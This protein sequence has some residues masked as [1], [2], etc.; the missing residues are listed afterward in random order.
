MSGRAHGSAGDRGRAGGWRAEWRLREGRWAKQGPRLPW[1]S[2]F[3]YHESDGKP[4]EDV[5]IVYPEMLKI[6]GKLH[7][8]CRGS[9]VVLHPVSPVACTVTVQCAPRDL[10]WAVLCL[11]SHGGFFGA[12]T[13]FLVGVCPEEWNFHP[14]L[15][16]V[17]AARL[18]QSPGTSFSYQRRLRASAAAFLAAD[19]L[20][21]GVGSGSGPETCGQWTCLHTGLLSSHASRATSFLRL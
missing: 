5:K 1:G 10:T 8:C 7:S 20:R 17:D 16:S 2:I 9:C 21:R 4:S 6:Y 14:G 11:S 13:A 15:A 19:D 12:T 3:L 18:S